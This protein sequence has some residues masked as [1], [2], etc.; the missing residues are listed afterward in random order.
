MLKILYEDWGR[1]GFAFIGQSSLFYFIIDMPLKNIISTV[2]I[3]SKPVNNDSIQGKISSLFRQAFISDMSFSDL[4]RFLAYYI[5]RCW[6][7]GYM[8]QIP[9]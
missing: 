7:D 9:L 4:P 1:P 3:A 6:D 8:L 5:Y 2:D